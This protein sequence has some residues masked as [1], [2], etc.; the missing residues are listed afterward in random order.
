VE[1]AAPN[2]GLTDDGHAINDPRVAPKPVEVVEITTTHHQ[3]F[4]DS[5][6]APAQS[7]DRVEPRADNDPRG[8]RPQAPL[9]EAAGQ[10]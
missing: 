5:I 7:S 6:A 9:S 4:G 1:E 10:S 2:A 8:P 3:L